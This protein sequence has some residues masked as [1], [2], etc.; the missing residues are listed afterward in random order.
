MLDACHQL[1]RSIA[2]PGGAL[3]PGSVW[4][5]ET[6][7]HSPGVSVVRKLLQYCLKE[8]PD[9]KRLL[10]ISCFSNSQGA[11]YEQVQAL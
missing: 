5:S 9:R 10:N 1:S 7:P 11:G 6:I 3:Q 8:E 2:G 4:P